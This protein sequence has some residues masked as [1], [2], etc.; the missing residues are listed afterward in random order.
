MADFVVANLQG[1]AVVDFTT[2]EIL[3]VAKSMSI[4]ARLGELVDSKEACD[5][6]VDFRNVKLIT[7]TMI[8]ELLRLKK[9]C[10]DAQV[11]LKFCGLSKELTVLLKK[12]KL[13]KSFDIFATREEALKM[14]GKRGR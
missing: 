7:S 12:L 14:I 8:G 13:D 5:L 2:S 4:G 6:V 11:E 9:K 10:G 1:I 3:D